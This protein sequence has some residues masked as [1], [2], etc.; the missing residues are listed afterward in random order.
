MKEGTHIKKLEKERRRLYTRIN[1]CCGV[2]TAM[3]QTH[4]Y[5]HELHQLIEF[6]MILED[7]L[8]DEID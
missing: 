1:N 2:V 8:R 7:E 6:A 4:F 3:L 5:Y